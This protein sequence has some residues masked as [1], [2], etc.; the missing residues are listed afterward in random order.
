MTR[1]TV[2]EP[3]GMQVA[4][5][6]TLRWWCTRTAR[7]TWWRARMP[8][9]WAPVSGCIHALPLARMSALTI[10]PPDAVYWPPPYGII[11]HK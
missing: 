3:T 8:T 9:R 2:C 10:V 1:Y 5:R 6:G 4:R 7:R 11:V